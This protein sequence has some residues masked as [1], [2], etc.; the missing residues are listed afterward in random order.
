MVGSLRGEPAVPTTRRPRWLVPGAAVA[1]VLVVLGAAAW[2]WGAG[3]GEGSGGGQ[4]AGPPVC[5]PPA[6]GEGWSRI[7]LNS[8]ATAQ[9]QLPGGSLLFE[10]Q[11]A[12]WRASGEG[13]QVVLAT[14]MQNKTSGP[15]YHGS[16][17]YQYLVVAQRS[18]SKVTCFSGGSVP[19]AAELVDEA[20][21]GFQVGC[22]PVGAIAVVLEDN[23]G[24]IR[25]TKDRQPGAC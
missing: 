14:S 17:R 16:W 8:D 20:L 2:W 5:A 25:V 12:H 6:A 3:S 7:A 10:V 24:R 23:K 4:Q 19:V 18:F 15:E 22:K 9:E 21:I 1:A 11:D 13:W